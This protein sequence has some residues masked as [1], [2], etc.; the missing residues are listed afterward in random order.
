MTPAKPFFNGKTLIY[1]ITS[2]LT[3]AA[4]LAGTYTWIARTPSAPA[5]ALEP[6]TIATDIEYAG[7]CP[8]LV[9][10]EKGYF[11]GEGVRVAI[12]PYNSGKAALSASL[13]GQADL[14]TSADLPI[15]FAAMKGQPVSVVATIFRTEKDHGIVGRRDRGIVT[16]D[17]LK[18]KR[19]GVT[20][21]TSGHFVLDAFLN[22]QRLS[23][24]EV[25]VRD[26]KPE[27]LSAA[28]ARGE[29]DAVATWEPFLGKSLAEVGTNGVIFSGEGVY[30]LPFNIAGTQDYVTSHPETIKK[31]LRA[32]VR[33]AR[34][35]EDA[36]DAAREIVAKAMKTDAGKLK[37]L[38]PSY[39]FNVSLDQSLLLAL[40]DETRWAIKNKLTAA[41]DMPNYLNHVQLAPLLA[42]SPAAVT[43]IH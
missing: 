28:L 39:R 16:P 9:A 1:A 14:A 10:Q 2:L 20:L 12:Q 26:L 37:D 8:I 31:I 35:C 34:L 18:G 42:V 41:I 3:A 40:E 30:E 43:V 36:P 17:A 24:H 13:Q 23:V 15:M 29:V 4:L 25:A 38:W 6:M 5:A 19:I 22:R 27:E 33:G 7:S 11:T 32:V 21:G